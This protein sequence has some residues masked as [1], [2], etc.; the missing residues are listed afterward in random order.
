MQQAAQGEVA[1]WSNASD[2]KS[3]VR[4]RT[5]GSNPTL[6]VQVQNLN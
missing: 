3:D 2:L 1:D 6:S 5:V 4:K